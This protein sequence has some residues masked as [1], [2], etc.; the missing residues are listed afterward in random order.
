MLETQLSYDEDVCILDVSVKVSGIRQM[1]SSTRVFEETLWVKG[2]FA[3][4]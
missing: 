4:V 1:A 2:S 3:V